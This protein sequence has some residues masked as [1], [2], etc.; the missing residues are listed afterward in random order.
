MSSLCFVFLI[1]LSMNYAQRAHRSGSSFACCEKILH[2]TDI[3]YEE[4]QTLRCLTLCFVD[5][6]W[7]KVP[8]N[9]PRIKMI[10]VTQRSLP[11]GLS[12]PTIL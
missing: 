9:L 5:N 3:I 8:K 4:L 1:K 2:N 12:T 6:L 11:L 7:E 10:L